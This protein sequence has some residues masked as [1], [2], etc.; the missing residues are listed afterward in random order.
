MDRCNFIEAVSGIQYPE[1]IVHFF[2]HFIALKKIV[3][4]T[5]KVTVVS[6][7]DSEIVFLINFS[8]KKDSDYA[9]SM[10]NSLGGSIVIYD[11]PMNVQVDIP[12][13]LQ[14]QIKLR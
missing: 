6:N 5:G 3:E 9:L 14:L 8:K 1:M 13:D 4:D 12:T 7:T 2:D 10:I 11:R